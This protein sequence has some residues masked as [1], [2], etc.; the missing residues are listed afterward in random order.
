ML[1]NPLTAMVPKHQS[2]LPKFKLT[3]Q[4]IQNAERKF[5][6][7]KAK[8]ND[9]RLAEA[10]LSTPILERLHNLKWE[11]G[12]I[13][14]GI[15]C[16]MFYYYVSDR[17]LLHCLIDSAA[18]SATGYLLPTTMQQFLEDIQNEKVFA[19][20]FRSYI[21][22]SQFKMILLSALYVWAICHGNPANDS[23]NSIDGFLK[24]YLLPMII[25]FSVYRF[26]QLKH[27]DNENLEV[28]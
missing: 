2:K 26:I 5:E 15:Y 10:A 27:V 4:G 13:I 20:Q 1:C 17:A 18:A 23:Y 19:K 7:I 6:E 21:S 9:Q 8:A 16:G 25:G 24:W 11:L 12:L 28:L 14:S 22:T 3:A